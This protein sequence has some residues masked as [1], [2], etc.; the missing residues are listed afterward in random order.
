MGT[1]SPESGELSRATA[2]GLGTDNSGAGRASKNQL[3]A[4]R[5]HGNCCDN[6]S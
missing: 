3:E 1:I 4:A 2:T 6:Q 5:N